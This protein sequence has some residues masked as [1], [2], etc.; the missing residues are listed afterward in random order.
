V[1]AVGAAIFVVLLVLTATTQNNALGTVV[2]IY[3]IVGGVLL[4]KVLANAER[5]RERE[6][7]A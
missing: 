3:G 4:G 6:Q 2:G 1:I 5:D 7:T